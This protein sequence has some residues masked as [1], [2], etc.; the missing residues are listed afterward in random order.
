[1]YSTE[2]MKVPRPGS[3]LPKRSIIQYSLGDIFI[4]EWDSKTQAEKETNIKGIANVLTNI[5]KTAGGY[6]WKYK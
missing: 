2:K 3:G 4:R 1:M 5:A 6:L